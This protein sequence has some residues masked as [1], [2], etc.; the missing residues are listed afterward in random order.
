MIKR[1]VGLQG[2]SEAW[3]RKL[4]KYQKSV[5]KKIL[6]LTN[7]LFLRKR[8]NKYLFTETLDRIK[9]C[10]HASLMTHWSKIYMLSCKRYWVFGLNS[11]FLVLYLFKK[12]PVRKIKR[13]NHQ[14]AKMG[15][16]NFS[17]VQK[18]NSF[19]GI[20]SITSFSTLS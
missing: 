2:L 1:W 12:A 8:F 15:L 17:F 5:L 4:A 18:L 7:F 6:F 10:N 19:I 9:I 13:L 16:A 3:S 14:V 11:Y 20:F